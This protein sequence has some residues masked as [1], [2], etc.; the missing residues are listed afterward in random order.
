MDSKEKKYAKELFRLN[1]LGATMF[2]GSSC[3]IENTYCSILHNSS[4]FSFIYR[5]FFFNSTVNSTL[6]PYFSEFKLGLHPANQS[7]YDVFTH[8]FLNGFIFYFTY[9]VCKNCIPCQA[10]NIPELTSVSKLPPRFLQKKT[11]AKE[12]QKKFFRSFLL[13]Q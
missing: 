12:D 3:S 7:L 5:N 13:R 6:K 1:T 2:I 10:R 4:C 8:N 11:Q 9:I